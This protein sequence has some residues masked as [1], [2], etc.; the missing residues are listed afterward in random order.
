MVASSAGGLVLAP[1]FHVHY[2]RHGKYTT[3]AKRRREVGERRKGGMLL[4]LGGG[5]E[6]ERAFRDLRSGCRETA[7]IGRDLAGGGR[8]IERACRDPRLR[9]RET[10]WGVSRSP[11]RRS[12]SRTSVSRSPFHI[13]RDGLGYVAISS[14]EV[15]T[16]NE[17]VVTFVSDV[18]RRPGYVRTSSAEV[19]TSAAHVARSP[20]K[21]V[22]CLA[23]PGF[24]SRYRR[25]LLRWEAVRPSGLSRRKSEV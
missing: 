17:R 3:P 9:C 13:S 1:P 25:C 7:G 10:G 8:D 5:R 15:A 18:A 24:P 6:L 14:A 23:T 20:E 22:R 11:R 2:R 12:R 4:P 19:A 21:V 16:S